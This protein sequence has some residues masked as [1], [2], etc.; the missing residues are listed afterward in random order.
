MGSQYHGGNFSDTKYEDTVCVY[1]N[2]INYYCAI[3]RRR[4]AA[5]HGD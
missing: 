3:K 5:E 4:N 2:S 1:I